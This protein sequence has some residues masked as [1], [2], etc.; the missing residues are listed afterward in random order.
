M[1]PQH[2]PDNRLSPYHRNWTNEW[3]QAKRVSGVHFVYCVTA[4]AIP[5]LLANYAVIHAH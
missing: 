1:H 5:G 2:S 4:E 3:G